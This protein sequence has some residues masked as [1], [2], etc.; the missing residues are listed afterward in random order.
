MTSRH[1]ILAALV[2]VMSTVPA[3]ASTSSGNEPL[4]TGCSTSYG[5][6]VTIGCHES[7]RKVEVTDTN[8]DVQVLSDGS[9]QAIRIGVLPKTGLENRDNIA[10]PPAA[11]LDIITKGNAAYSVMLTAVPYQPLETVALPCRNTKQQSSVPAVIATPTYLP[12]MPSD[13]D[14]TKV[15]VRFTVRGDA[16]L[17]CTTVFGYRDQ[18]WCQLAPG[19]RGMVP[20]AYAID[21][22]GTR[23][24]S[25]HVVNRDWLVIE[26]MPN[27]IRLT[28]GTLNKS[29]DIIRRAL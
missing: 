20:S 14:L 5:C 26:T 19:T 2:L 17:A 7:L 13:V 15:D 28:W 12:E 27:D 6:I 16:T 8:F 3:H 1:V 11:R 9:D 25:A 23:P 21:P 4:S 18:V 10:L 29:I 24:L 22:V